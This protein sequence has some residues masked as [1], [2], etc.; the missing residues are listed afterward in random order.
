MRENLFT[1]H[2]RCD[3]VL[4]SRL[5]RGPFLTES[6]LWEAVKSLPNSFSEKVTDGVS[7]ST[8]R[9]HTKLV[10][11][12][13]E[14]LATTV[15]LSTRSNPRHPKTG[16]LKTALPEGA[17]VCPPNVAGVRDTGSGPHKANQDDQLL[18]SG[19]CSAFS[20]YRTLG[21]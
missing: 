14:S 7:E 17:E 5:I 18:S 9:F 2:P 1:I 13:Y 20:V 19:L 21:K 11:G 10:S 15:R 12:F 6:H 4:L 8:I 16:Q 3:T